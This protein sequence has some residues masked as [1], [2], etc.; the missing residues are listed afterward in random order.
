MTDYADWQT[1]QA[2]ATAIYTTK[3][4]LAGAPTAILFNAGVNLPHGS[5][6]Q[7]DGGGNG[8]N[9]VPYLSFNPA[10]IMTPG[11]G[12]TFPFAR[13]TFIMLNPDLSE[14]TQEHWIIPMMA[15]YDKVAV[16]GGDGRPQ[17]CGRLV[18]GFL[19]VFI[20]NLDT[21]DATLTGI[22]IN[23]DSRNAPQISSIQDNPGARTYPG[24]AP[25]TA[26]SQG[27]GF[28]RTLGASQT[29]TIAPGATINYLLALYSGKI[30][31]DFKATGGTAAGIAWTLKYVNGSTGGVGT[32]GTLASG[33]SGAGAQFGPSEL[34][35]P[36]APMVLTVVSS[37][38]AATDTLVWSATA[39]GD[40]H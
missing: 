24:T 35:V 13:V 19:K 16:F 5:T 26:P 31:F 4:P 28:D 12:S 18:G 30:S 7:V 10:V 17:G 1:P 11:V 37:E 39:A 34:D 21:V 22:D 8:I 3:V 6:V 9:T 36:R 33:T 14:A 38:G 40:T 32:Y 15:P 2:H 20:K 23:G 29:D 25:F 27:T